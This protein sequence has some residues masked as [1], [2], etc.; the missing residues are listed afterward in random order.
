ME[1]SNLVCK[2]RDSDSFS[3]GQVGGNSSQ[4]NIKPIG[5]IMAF[6]S[7]FLIF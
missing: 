5:S 2:A 1:S 7:S 4:S 6:G 3:T